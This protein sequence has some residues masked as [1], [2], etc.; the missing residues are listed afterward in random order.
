M[1]DETVESVLNGHSERL[2]LAFNF[3]HDPIPSPIQITKNLRICGDCRKISLHSRNLSLSIIRCFDRCSDQ[4]DQPF[5]SMFNPYQWFES[6]ASFS[7]WS[8]FMQW[9]ILIEKRMLVS[10][11]LSHTLLITCSRLS[12]WPK[13]FL[14]VILG[15][16]SISSLWDLSNSF[17]S[18]VWLSL[19][20]VRSCWYWRVEEADQY[21]HCIIISQLDKKLRNKFTLDWVETRFSSSSHLFKNQND[22]ETSLLP[23]GKTFVR[24]QSFPFDRDIQRSNPRLC[25]QSMKTS[26]NT[27]EIIHQMQM[28]DITTTEDADTD[29][30]GKS[31]DVWVLSTNNGIGRSESLIR[32]ELRKTLAKW[33]VRN[34]LSQDYRSITMDWKRREKEKKEWLFSLFLMG[35]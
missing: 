18:C 23:M 11:M 17:L 12:F 16:D 19:S 22:E 24:W 7:G 28:I 29:G 32:N 4:V 26:D 15:I 35:G 5:S 31:I 1:P 13:R 9:S 33:N 6:N 3:I 2:A 25:L 30:N 27:L 14:F 21:H 8:M 20:P 34:F 10:P